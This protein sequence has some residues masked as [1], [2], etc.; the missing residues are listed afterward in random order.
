MSLDGVYLVFIRVFCYI[1]FLVFIYCGFRFVIDFIYNCFFFVNCFRY[2][3]F[4]VFVDVKFVDMEVDC[5]FGF[6]VLY[7]GFI[8]F[9]D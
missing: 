9:W 2:S 6:V 5:S 1:S 4:F 8:G 3:W 7:K